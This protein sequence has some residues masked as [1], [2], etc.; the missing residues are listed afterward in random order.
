MK[1][2]F[3]LSNSDSD[4]MPTLKSCT[5]SNRQLKNDIHDHRLK[6]VDTHSELRIIE[7]IAQI[8]INARSFLLLFF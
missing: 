6:K 4:V 2:S 1:K 3:A 8:R 5:T 7:N